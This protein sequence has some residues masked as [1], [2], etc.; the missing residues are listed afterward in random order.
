MLSLTGNEC[1]MTGC[2]GTFAPVFF[3]FVRSCSESGPECPAKLNNGADW[4]FPEPWL[5]PSLAIPLSDTLIALLVAQQD[6]ERAS[7]DLPAEMPGR[8][9]R[10]ARGLQE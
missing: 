8:P 9:G 10:Q 3:V 1:L 6:S 7:H 2:T 5:E 4:I